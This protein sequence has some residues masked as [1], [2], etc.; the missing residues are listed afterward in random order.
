MSNEISQYDIFGNVIDH[1][2][3]ETLSYLVKKI[4][5]HEKKIARAQERILA[6]TEEIKRIKTAIEIMQKEGR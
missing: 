5:G 2:K 3:N 6:E 4:K 1:E